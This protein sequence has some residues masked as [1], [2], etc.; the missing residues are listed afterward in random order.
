MFK[1][2]TVVVG[3]AGHVGLPLAIMLASKGQKT[4]IYDISNEA[5]NKVSAGEMPF[6]EPGAEGLLRQDGIW[7]LSGHRGSRGYS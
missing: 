5:V 2:N 7:Q 3:G 4:V 1:K 6:L